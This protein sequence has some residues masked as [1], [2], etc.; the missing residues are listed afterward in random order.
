[1]YEEKD[2]KLIINTSILQLI[3][4]HLALNK[5]IFSEQI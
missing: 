3:E 1:M 5:S 2:T 4:T